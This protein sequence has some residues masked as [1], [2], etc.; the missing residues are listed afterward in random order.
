MCVDGCGI[1]EL[2]NFASYSTAMTGFLSNN[3]GPVKFKEVKFKS[4]SN[5]YNR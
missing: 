5:Q 3:M 4:E 2:S 1:G